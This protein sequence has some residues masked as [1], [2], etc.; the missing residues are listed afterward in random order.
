[1]PA[2]LLRPPTLTEQADMERN[3]LRARI[4][5]RF[6]QGRRSADTE[7][8]TN[9][10]DQAAQIMRQRA[11]FDISREPAHIRDSY[12]NQELGRHCLLAGC[13]KAESRW[14]TSPIAITIP[15]TRTSIPT[16]SSSASSTAPA[17]P[18]WTTWRSVA[19]SKARWWW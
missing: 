19:C 8:Y 9:S 4:N 2:N 14:S 18:C 5:Q 17:P 3:Q 15:T 16:S 7:A 1:P 6:A 11:I 13:W 10:Y 12:G